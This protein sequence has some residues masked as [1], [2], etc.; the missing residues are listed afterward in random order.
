MKIQPIILLC[1]KYR[2]NEN[3]TF[4]SFLPEYLKINQRIVKLLN[5]SGDTNNA[6]QITENILE[7]FV[8][9]EN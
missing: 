3:F 6:F 2:I 9:I 1:H 4:K 8:I 5:A 7:T